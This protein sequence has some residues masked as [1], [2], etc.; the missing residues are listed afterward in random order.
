MGCLLLD[1][2]RW[3]VELDRRQTEQVIRALEM[4]E[5]D[6]VVTIELGISAVKPSKIK[7]PQV[8]FWFK[9]KGYKV[10]ADQLVNLQPLLSVP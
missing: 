2:G 7:T 9:S 6:A 5:L 10:P 3:T 4:F 8:R 1:L